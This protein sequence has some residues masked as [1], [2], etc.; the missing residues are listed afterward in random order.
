MMSRV[1][2][3][4][5]GV[6]TL[7]IMALTWTSCGPDQ[8]GPQ[9]RTGASDKPP[10]HAVHTEALQAV[11]AR[12]GESAS[13]QWPQEV[14]EL[15]ADLA[16]KDRQRRFHEARKLATALIDASEAIPQ[17]VESAPMST[18]DRR[19]FLAINRQL[20]NHATELQAAAAVEDLDRMQE[21]LSVIK[22]TCYGCHAQFS[23]YTGPLNFGEPQS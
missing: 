2:M 4:S 20:R 12:L 8:S 13:Q 17:A 1:P 19:A 15:K 11:M 6:V 22:T 5:L 16:A 3:A 14:S 18:D 10:A 7:A 23:A 21:T 9:G